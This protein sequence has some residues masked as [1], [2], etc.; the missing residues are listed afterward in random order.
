MTFLKTPAARHAAI[1]SLLFGLSAV[2]AACGDSSS[3]SSGGGE[4]N[5]SSQSGGGGEGGEGEGGSDGGASSEAVSSAS[6]DGQTFCFNTGDTIR[7]NSPIFAYD[8]VWYPEYNEAEQAEYLFRH[9]PECRASSA[10]I[11]AALARIGYDRVHAGAIVRMN[12]VSSSDASQRGAQALFSVNPEVA[13]ANWRKPYSA[14][15]S[16]GVHQDGVYKGRFTAM[17]GYST[18]PK[19]LWINMSDDGNP[20][21]VEVTLPH[22]LPMRFHGL[23]V[24]HDNVCFTVPSPLDKPVMAVVGNSLAHGEGQNITEETFAWIASRELGYELVNLA[25]GGSTITPEMVSMNFAA[26]KRV[27]LAV[28]EWGFND[29][30]GGG[31]AA[32]KTKFAQVLENIRAVHATAKIAVIVPFP[33]LIGTT[34]NGKTYLQGYGCVQPGTGANADVGV[35]TTDSTTIEDWRQMERDVVAERA[36]AGDANIVVVT[37]GDLGMEANLT[38]LVT[39]GIHL[40]VAGAA[41]FG[42]LLAAALRQ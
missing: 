31:I 34:F 32:A 7:P 30:N 16:F 1:L 23:L 41:K 24:K 40:S 25:I 5:L 35:C 19:A 13:E 22:Q 42:P 11:S 18:T 36:A 12:F 17:N 20:H 39:D 29:W 14:G 6:G 33:T 21:T 15:P 37:P 8:G 2:L 4:G 28:V 27:D 10:C 38:D 26:A 9:S 3:S